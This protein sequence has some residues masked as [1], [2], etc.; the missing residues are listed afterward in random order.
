MKP[1]GRASCYRAEVFALAM[2]A[3]LVDP[4]TRI[5]TDSASAIHAIKG[6][7]P[8][9]TL[10]TPIHHI[11]TL[12]VQ[13]DLSLTHVRG[14]T[15]IAGNEI[16]DSLAK[17]ACLSLPPPPPQKPVHPWDVCV[18]GELQAPP[19]KTWVRGLRPQHAQADIHPLSWKPLTKTGW[20]AWLFG[21]K[22]VKGYAHP[23]SYWRN[24]PSPSPCRYCTTFHNASVHGH[25]GLCPS[26]DNPLV[27]AWLQSWGPHF[28]LISSWRQHAQPRDRFL[29]GKLVLPNSL[30]AYLRNA[31]GP[32]AANM[33][34]RH[35]QSHILPCIT[36]VLPSWL[37]EE[38]V[39]FKRRLSAYCPEGWEHGPRPL[40]CQPVASRRRLHPPQQSQPTILQFLRPPRPN[41]DHIP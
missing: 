20:L 24:Q 32:R 10:A 15:G 21:A 3:S 1:R 35:F 39:T 18:D 23:S 38:K 5:Y 14:H 34:I 30:V 13:K 4:G 19:H 12:L 22:S 8:R 16:A 25:I 17:T 11:R 2:A 6:T 7:S 40:P 37:P 36:A 29:L 27:D 28:P 9:V 41:P 33:C 31:M 26:L